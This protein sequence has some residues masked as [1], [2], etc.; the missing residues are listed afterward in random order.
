MNRENQP[1]FI[2]KDMGR[3]VTDYSL[4]TSGQILD[5]PFYKVYE[6]L[7]EMRKNVI[8]KNSPGEH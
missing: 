6:V 8:K 3:N 4:K 7:E 1:F 5:I 2:E